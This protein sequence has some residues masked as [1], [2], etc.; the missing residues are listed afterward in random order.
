MKKKKSKSYRQKG[1][2]IDLDHAMVALV[3]A[4]IKRAKYDSPAVTVT[5]AKKII[6][7]GAKYV[8]F[9][10]IA[11]EWIKAMLADDPLERPSVKRALTFFKLLISIE[12]GL[13]DG[14]R[15]MRSMGI[16]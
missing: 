4:N 8:A 2:E 5:S 10:Q 14:L 11:R 15:E 13:R 3:K 6:A 9:L 12:T 7:Q 16:Y 1:G